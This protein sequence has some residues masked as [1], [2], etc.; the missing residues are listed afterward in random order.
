MHCGM[1][2]S[3]SLSLLH[4]ISTTKPGA[5]PQ[6]LLRGLQKCPAMTVKTRNGPDQSTQYIKN[7]VRNFG[8]KFSK[9]NT[10]GQKFKGVKVK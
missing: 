6:L 8:R 10:E 7:A 1:G 4:T 3:L 2:V 5:Y 9:D